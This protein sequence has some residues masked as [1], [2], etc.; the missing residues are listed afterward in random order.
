MNNEYSEGETQ[1]ESMEYDILIVGG[2]PAG[3][4][5]AIKLKQL[6]LKEKR[7]ILTKSENELRKKSSHNLNK[8][9]VDQLLWEIANVWFIRGDNDKK[10]YTLASEA[11]NRSRIHV[12][13]ADWTAG[14]ASWRMDNKKE[15]QFHF[16]KLAKSNTAS[17]WNKSA[18]AFWAARANLLNNNPENVKYWLKLGARFDKTFYGLLAKRYLGKKSKFISKELKLEN[19]VYNQLIKHKPIL[20]S[21]ALSQIDKK[22]LADREIYKLIKS[23][24]EH[25]KEDLLKLATTLDLPNSTLHLGLK[26]LEPSSP[27]YNTII[28]PIPKWYELMNAYVDRALILAFVKQESN[29]NSYAK[30]PAGARGLMQLMPRTA[31]FVASDRSLRFN[32]LNSLYETQLNLRLGSKYITYLMQDS[33]IKDNLFFIA[34]AYNAGPNNLSK[35]L[36][37]TKYY[38][39]PLLFI[40]SIPSKET[41]LFVERI[42]TNFWIY[43]MRFG[44]KTP[45]LDDVLEGRWPQYKHFDKK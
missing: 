21:L 31:S 25:Q 37:K 13:I 23:S 29:F 5:A 20:R 26:S 44:Q 19:S 12:E 35:W 24:N 8:I 28:F 41:R 45:S 6:A 4:S 38:N 18:G 11:A 17:P 30:S 14:L 2:G 16:E 10:A 1:R 33:N 43:R 34:T 7:E 9:E 36:K 32:K 15:A 27:Y 40:E 22:Y 39:D 42:M 3:L